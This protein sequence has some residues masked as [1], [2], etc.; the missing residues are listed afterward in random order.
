M[1][2]RRVFQLHLRT[3]M[4]IARVSYFSSI[5]G[6]GYRFVKPKFGFIWLYPN[7]TVQVAKERHLKKILK[8]LFGNYI[9]LIGKYPSPYEPPQF[10]LLKPV[11]TC[12]CFVFLQNLY[13]MSSK[14]KE[15]NPVSN[16]LQ[17]KDHTA[18]RCEQWVWTVTDTCHSPFRLRRSVKR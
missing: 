13:L 16:C 15:W 9:F 5:S 2:V 8:P 10:P 6:S 4:G 3:K 11:C 12:L 7:S 18:P 17:T 1:G 14:S